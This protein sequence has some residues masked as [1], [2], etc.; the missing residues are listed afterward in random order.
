MAHLFALELR[1]GFQ[2]FR[3][4]IAGMLVC[5]T[6][7]CAE[8]LQFTD[9]VKPSFDGRAVA[10][11]PSLDGECKVG[12]PEKRRRDQCEHGVQSII[13]QIDE[14]LEP[15]NL[16]RSRRTCSTRRREVPVKLSQFGRLELFTFK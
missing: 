10:A 1:T 2:N 8:R 9:S 6:G 5:I 16:A 7:Q 3:E 12:S 15:G 11:P 4:G 13:Q 14:S